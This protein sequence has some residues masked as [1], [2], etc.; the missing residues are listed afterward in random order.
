MPWT[1]EKRKEYMK[2]YRKEYNQTENGKMS[3][4]ISNWKK[5]GLIMDTYWDYVTIY[6]HWLVSTHCE[7]CPKEFDNTKHN[8]KCMDHCHLTGEYRNILCLKCNL[9]DRVNN[10]SGVPNI[11]WHKRDKRW[12]YQRIIN[13]KTHTKRFTLKEDAIKY[14]LEYEKE[15]I[16]KN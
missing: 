16:Y 14:K 7:K 3:N 12:T 6:N 11:C 1:K 10:T 9:N 5:I 4:K 2:E 15:N 13:K 8:D